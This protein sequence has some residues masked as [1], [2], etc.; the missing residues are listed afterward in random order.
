MLPDNNQEPPPERPDYGILLGIVAAVGYSLVNLALRQLSDSSSAEGSGWEV[1]VTAIKA[2]ATGLTA[3]VVVLYRH[4]NGQ[5]A[6]PPR[7]LL[8]GL[9]VASLIMQVGGNLCFQLSLGYL[10]LAITVPIVFACI[11]C[12]GAVA[13][14]ALLGDPITRD[15]V[16]AMLVMAAAI[17]MLSAGSVSAQPITTTAPRLVPSLTGLAMALISGCS[18]GLVGVLIRYFVRSAF[19]VESVLV[20]FTTVGCSLLAGVAVILSGWQAIWHNTVMVW[21]MLAIASITNAVAFFALAYALKT[22]DVNRINVINASQNA[23]CAVG[24]VILFQEELGPL[25]LGGIGLTI[26]G[27]LV[28]SRRSGPSASG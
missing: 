3:W 11:I 1:W 15:T 27:L 16:F 10:G 25:A 8:P 19:P 17:V 28:L 23:M 2:L 18:Y 20:V 9:F 13:G 21:P 26:A 12:V 7:R 4:W 14:R 22:V 24:A 5:T 6:F